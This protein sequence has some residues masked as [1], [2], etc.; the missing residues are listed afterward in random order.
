MLRAC[1]RSLQ[2]HHSR[3]MG[4]LNPVYQP[5]SQQRW[6][7]FLRRRVQ[8]FRRRGWWGRA[9]TL[10]G[11]G[12]G[13]AAVYVTSCLALYAVHKPTVDE[14]FHPREDYTLERWSDVEPTLRPGDVVLMMGD[15]PISSAIAVAQFTFSKMHPSAMRYSH[16]AMIVE[17]AVVERPALLT[18]EERRRGGF[19]S[20]TSTSCASSSEN[21]HQ[22]S[23]HFWWRC[24]WPSSASTTNSAP[25]PPLSVEEVLCMEGKRLE[26]GP[27]TIRRGAVLLEAMDNTDYN[28]PDVEGRVRHF[29]VQLVEA[30]KRLCSVD[31]ARGTPAYHHFSVRRLRGPLGTNPDGLD[32]AQCASLRAFAERNVGRPLDRC[33]YYPV[34]FGWPRLY[35][36]LRPERSQRREVSCSELLVE[37]LQELGLLRRRWRWVPVHNASAHVTNAVAPTGSPRAQPTAT[38]LGLSPG[39]RQSL[40]VYEHCYTAG[41][42]FPSQPWHAR[43]RPMAPAGTVIENSEAL[44][45][46]VT[47]A[48]E[49]SLQAGVLRPCGRGQQCQLQWY[50]AHMS[51]QT[52]PFHFTEGPCERLLDW[53]DGWCF[54][55]EI[56]MEIAPRVSVASGHE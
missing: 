18:A 26:A 3:I 48:E 22:S 47:A 34:A 40:H 21:P 49:G 42:R 28:V 2:E 36:W 8:C 25:S 20:H 5:A 1:R 32:D 56:K 4:G 14:M 7:L 51:L 54:G 9:F 35:A 33:V 10:G 17:P 55:P 27:C 6:V 12:C 30:T 23:T 19:A 31:P 39:A 29:E 13:I 37:A 44:T 11:Y 53:A 38:D 41:G 16:V 43:P 45:T 15:G 24:F 46:P 50:Y 52:A